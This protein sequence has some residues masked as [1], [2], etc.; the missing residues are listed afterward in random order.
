MK[1]ITNLTY[2]D[3]LLLDIQ[4]LVALLGTTLIEVDVI[5]GTTT[6]IGHEAAVEAADEVKRYFLSG[7]YS[8]PTSPPTML[9]QSLCSDSSRVSRFEYLSKPVIRTFAPISFVSC[10]LAGELH[11]LAGV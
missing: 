10:G 7:S 11:K 4:G 2:C 1:L 9:C 5:V 8:S 3:S 6:I